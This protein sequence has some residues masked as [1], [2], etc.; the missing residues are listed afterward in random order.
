M[1]TFVTSVYK[2]RWAALVL[3]L[4]LVLESVAPCNSHEDTFAKTYASPTVQLSYLVSIPFILCSSCSET[5]WNKYRI[6]PRLW[7]HCQELRRKDEEIK[8][9]KPVTTV[10]FK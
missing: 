1:E 4:D 6:L 2:G 8:K 3:L 10:T 9:S 5:R 7:P